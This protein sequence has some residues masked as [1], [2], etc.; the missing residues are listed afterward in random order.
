[1]FRPP[2]QKVS[3][4]SAWQRALTALILG[5]TLL[6]LSAD[7]VVEL[8]VARKSEQQNLAAYR[9]QVRS[10]LK[11]EVQAAVTVAAFMWDNHY[12]EVTKEEVKKKVSRLLESMKSSAGGYYFGADFEGV[13][14]VGPAKGQNMLEVRDKNG[15][16]VVQELIKTA[17]AG[18]GFVEYVMPPIDG[19]EQAPKISYVLPFDP[20]SWYIGAG[21]S[22][23]EI[24]VIE[25]EVARTTRMRFLTISVANSLLAAVLLAALTLINRLLYRRVDEE[26]LSIEGYLSR[27][28]FREEDIQG[29]TF[30]ITELGAIAEHSNR[31]VHALFSS[32]KE[33]RQSRLRFETV[34]RALPD[35][36]FMVDR[37]G[38]FLSYES[39]E[40]KKLIA[41]PQVFLGKR[42]SDMLPPEISELSMARIEESFASG[43]LT[44]LEYSLY[45]EN[46]RRWYEARFVPVDQ[47]QLMILVRDT[48]EI[49]EVRRK[50]EYLSYHDQLTDL[51]N[52]RF[53]E[54]EMHRLDSVRH[55]P[56]SIVMIDVNGLKMINDAFGHAKG[57]ELLT[58]VSNLLRAM[59]RSGEIIARTGGDEFV[60]LLPST[61][62]AAAEAFIRRLYEYL[63]EQ[64]VE[65]WITSISV[66]SDTKESPEEPVE[67]VYAQAEK[68][69]YRRKLAESQ[70]MRNQTVQV[71]M[72]TLN[73]KNQREKRHS[74]RV[75]ALCRRLGEALGMD[76]LAVRELETAG[77][78]HDIGKIVVDEKLLNKAGPLTEEEYEEV[79]KHPEISYQILRAVDTYATIAE[80]ILSHHERWDGRGYPRG[81]TGS[82]ISLTARIIAVSDTYEAMTATR[83]Y[84]TALSHD[85]AIEEI[86]RNA[87]TQFDPQVVKVFVS[88]DFTGLE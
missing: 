27:T 5:M 9:E 68:N 34:V 10:R 51:Y 69:M 37:E 82:Q 85:T 86:Q 53:F 15:L 14:T 29:E 28:A 62:R 16:F 35:L 22:L 43:S 76:Y 46:Q 65:E 72:R 75:S 57:D 54:E 84:R 19:Y 44:L 13:S 80:D 17:K 39:L 61:P 77:L 23:T 45:P 50:N 31:L 60:I 52:R 6:R 1:M 18:G 66:G 70:S 56:L 3:I 74:E 25:Q 48:T 38:R 11:E 36:V 41:P 33:L 26:I 78:L 47:N 21:I 73:E 7:I 40:N 83:T 8:T 42:I 64:P 87:G 81:L 24:A 79:K 59:C 4:R 55:L 71:I 58:S 88:M 2:P 67:S 49:S 63:E 20:F 12:P 30:R 32:M